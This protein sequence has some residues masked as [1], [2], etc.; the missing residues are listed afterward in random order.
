MPEF[1]N[2]EMFRTVLESLQTGVYMVDREQRILFWND[3]AEKITGYLRQE[4]VGAFCRGQLIANDDHTK[5]VLTD[6]AAGLTEV[7]RQGKPS[8]MDVSLR[9]KL[10]HRIFVRLR[11]VPIRNEHGSIIGAAESIEEDLAAS[12]WN[13]RQGKLAGYGC[14]D[15][16]TGVL[17]Q[18]FL[19]SHLREAVATYSD[20][21]VPFSLM[22]AEIDRLDHLRAAYGA[23]VIPT[24]LRVAAQSIENSLRPTDF[25]GR[26]GEYRFLALL[27]ECGESEIEL[28]GER[29]KEAISTSEVEWWGDEW[30]IT[31]SFGGTIVR[32]GD[33]VS[34]MIE[35]AEAAI[36]ESLQTGGNRVSVSLT[37]VQQ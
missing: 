19:L 9:H 17:N 4:V 36:G 11:A 2:P 32:H 7:L 25:L 18:G 29:L 37:A 22:L 24:V 26:F 15:P 27:S 1:P 13:R 28:V 5:N 30:A 14:L 8:V 12:D 6:A 31:A 21:E 33:S 3:G 10:G 16:M 34:S 35:R 23:G 20:Y